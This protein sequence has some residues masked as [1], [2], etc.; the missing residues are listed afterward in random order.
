MNF[1]LV[2]SWKLKLKLRERREEGKFDVKLG[3]TAVLFSSSL[4]LP[5]VLSRSIVKC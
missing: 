3:E 4:S 5:E 1:R 2:S